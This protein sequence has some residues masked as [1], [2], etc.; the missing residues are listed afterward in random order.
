MASNTS[1]KSVAVRTRAAKGRRQQAMR[2]PRNPDELW[3]WVRDTLGVELKRRGPLDDEDA[4]FDYLAWA[5]FEGAGRLRASLSEVRD[6]SADAVVLACRGGG[7]T[8]LGAVA[9]AL[10][11][12]FKPGIEVKILA[13][14]V[15]QGSK[16]HAH[17]RDIFAIPALAREVAGRAT[18][19]RIALR[20]KSSVT[21]LAQSETSIR[22]VRA[23]KIRCDEVEMFTLP[24]WEAAQLVTRSKQ[25]GPV[26]VTG[27]I[28]VL[29][30]RH[31]LN[32][33]MQKLIEECGRGKRRLF[34]WGVGSVLGTCE[35]WRECGEEREAAKSPDREVAKSADRQVAEPGMGR[36]PVTQAGASE[37]G[38]I[39]LPVMPTTSRCALWDECRGRAKRAEWVAGHIG[40]G[41]AIDMK[42]RVGE[43][44]WA[45]EMTNARPR[46]EHLVLPEFDV[47]VHVVEGG[48]APQIANWQIANQQIEQ[49]AA[50]V[51]TG[52][53]CGMDFGFRSPTVILWGIQGADGVLWIVDERVEKEMVT[54]E[55]AQAISESP[56]GKPRWIGADPAG[57]QVN[58]QT[59]L[60]T[61]QLLAAAGLTVRTRPDWV[62]ASMLLLHT[63]L[64]P[65][66][67]RPRLF[68]H[69]R[70][71]RLIES[72]LSYHYDEER[73]NDVEPV[74]DGPDHAV[75]ALRYLVMNLD[76]PGKAR[77]GTYAGFE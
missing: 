13:G 68:I 67:G 50:A 77:G 9:T 43:A 36:H 56:W 1:Q 47:N 75:D 40:V 42:G 74:K 24:V 10:D 18:D 34:R 49:G 6:G 30:T 5:F 19:R 66:A 62:H 76:K 8:Y 65:A 39:H 11:M 7:K 69:A 61:V 70:C 27:T 33:V 21:V 53:F 35:E 57:R 17:L 2:A 25:C 54:A 26:A 20:N 45:A 37:R 28:E 38:A 60:S 55:H 31:K 14:S 29:S 3:L 52:L 64:K 4:P 22:G 15:E 63:R 71:T 58:A 32:G 23:Q 48:E 51:E 72:L 41:D 44:R 73:P 16:M 59:G 12:L 46:R